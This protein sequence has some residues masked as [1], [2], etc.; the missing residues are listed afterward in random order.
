MTIVIS[1][2]KTKGIVPLCSLRHFSSQETYF[3]QQD[4]MRNLTS[5][6]WLPQDPGQL[7]QPEVG[8]A[9]VSDSHQLVALFPRNGDQDGGYW[10][11][12]DYLWTSE[13]YIN[14]GVGLFRRSPSTITVSTCKSGCMDVLTAY[15]AHCYESGVQVQICMVA[16][17]ACHNH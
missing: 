11:S 17:C 6:I 7:L 14:A 10:G 4:P 2:L 13:N 9:S 3:Q 16:W 5:Q 1:A 8:S 15:N 12:P